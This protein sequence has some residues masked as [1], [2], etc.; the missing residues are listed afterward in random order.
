MSSFQF[1]YTITIIHRIILKFID[2]NNIFNITV[3]VVLW[4]VSR[5]SYSVC[6]RELNDMLPPIALDGVAG[7]IYYLILYNIIGLIAGAS[8]ALLIHPIDTLKV[9]YNPYI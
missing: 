4:C 9:I 1:W 5:W 3:M 2:K 6:R 8:S 7:L